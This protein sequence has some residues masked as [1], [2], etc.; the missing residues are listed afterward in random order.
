MKIL[1]KMTNDF[2]YF[3][4]LFF[5][6]V[7]TFAIIGNFNFIELEQFQGV[8]P[9]SLTVFDAALGNFDLN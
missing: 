2:L 5:I 3:F 1:D 7:I 8:Y 6:L 4:V 9:S